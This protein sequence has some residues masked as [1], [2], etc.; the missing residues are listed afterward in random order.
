MATRTKMKRQLSQAQAT[1]LVARFPN[2]SQDDRVLSRDVTS[3][4]TSFI[5]ISTVTR[6]TGNL[7]FV[8]EEMERSYVCRTCVRI[9]DHYSGITRAAL[10][11]FACFATA[12]TRRAKFG[13]R[14]SSRASFAQRTAISRTKAP[15]HVRGM[16]ILG[17]AT[18]AFV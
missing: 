18:A 4:V 9:C 6:P 11:T 17:I 12:I 3:S 7:A 13:Q 16:W 10:S 8:L 14:Y 2:I 15:L 1:L 5:N